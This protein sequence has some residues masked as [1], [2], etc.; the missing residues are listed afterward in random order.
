MRSWRKRSAFWVAAV[1][2]DL[3][4][5]A[6]GFYTPGLGR[7]TTADWTI[8]GSHFAERCQAFILIA[9]Y[10]PIFSLADTIR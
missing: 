4:G 2:I 3:V 1:A 5:G 10:L 6:V 9:L 8:S 7:S